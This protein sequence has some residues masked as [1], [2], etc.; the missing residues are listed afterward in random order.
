M[1]NIIITKERW[2]NVHSPDRGGHN[3]SS[4][5]LKLKYEDING[6]DSEIMYQRLIKFAFYLINFIEQGVNIDLSFEGNEEMGMNIFKEHFAIQNAC[7]FPHIGNKTKSMT[8]IIDWMSEYEAEHAQIN[9]IFNPTLIIGTGTI[10]PQWNKSEKNWTTLGVERLKII[11][12]DQICNL[13]GYNI[14]CLKDDAFIMSD[15]KLY[16]N[17]YHPSAPEFNSKEKEIA[18]GVALIYKLHKDG[19]L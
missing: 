1:L 11:S 12:R 13:V 18:R 9:K 5:L 3:K 15:G 6:D 19:R 10:K 17:I 8:P 14:S 7:W 2:D 4:E 16:V